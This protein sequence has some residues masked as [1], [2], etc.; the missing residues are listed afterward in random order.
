V[1]IPEGV[2]NVTLMSVQTAGIN[3]SSN[4]LYLSR[5][6]SGSIVFQGSNSINRN[7]Y[8][9]KSI[10][11]A[12]YYSG[13]GDIM[14][15][16]VENSTYSFLDDVNNA[17]ATN[18]IITYNSTSGYSN[19]TTY[20]NCIFLDATFQ[21]NPSNSSFNY[22]VFVDNGVIGIPT[23]TNHFGADAT[24]LFEGT[25]D[26]SPDGAWQLP[27][28]SDAKGKGAGGIDCGIF[29]G[30]D[31]YILSGLP[32]VPLIYEMNTPSTVGG[33]LN[34]NLKAKSNQ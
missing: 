29:G 11:N 21:N 15:I 8:V 19:N 28:T 5:V 14:F 1:T 30:D 34:V 18:C 27:E 23:G 24:T 6:N 16:E 32:P 9:D 20:N 13:N 12:A 10:F 7:L 25:T 33:T 3:V 2:E 17:I 26:N 31:P 4:S 22:C